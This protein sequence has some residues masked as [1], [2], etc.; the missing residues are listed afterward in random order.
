MI[1]KQWNVIVVD[2]SPLSRVIYVE[3][4]IH[5]PIVAK[6]IRHLLL[7]LMDCTGVNLESVHLVGHSLGAQIA[8]MTGHLLDDLTGLKIGRITGNIYLHHH[9]L[10]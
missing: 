8:G 7:F 2:W 9:K 4:R 3:A 6:Q 1:R 10:Q 5:T